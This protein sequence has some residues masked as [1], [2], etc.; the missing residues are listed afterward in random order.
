M[1]QYWTIICIKLPT[2]HSVRP[3]DLTAQNMAASKEIW[4]AVPMAGGFEGSQKLPD[5]VPG[6][7]NFRRVPGYK[8]YCCGQPTIAGF[9]NVLNK[10]CGDTYPKD[11]EIIWMNMRQEPNLYING[12]PVCARAAGKIGEYTEL[13]EVKQDE[14]KAAELEF[15]KVCKKRVEENAGKLKVTDV[16]KVKKEVEVKEMT[17]LANVIET[18]KEKFPGLYHM[19]CNSAAPLESDFDIVSRT[20][21]GAPIITP[22]IINDQVVSSPVCSESSK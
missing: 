12:E 19:T 9:E 2:F 22:I 5:P 14:I 4:K 17:A 18:L 6:Y 10:V 3:Q 7:P 11:G 8:I 15:L 20:L 1:N 21:V 13:G 16:N